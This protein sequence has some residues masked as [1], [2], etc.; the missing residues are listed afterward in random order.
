[1]LILKQRRLHHFKLNA[2]TSLV[3][4]FF[5]QLKTDEIPLFPD[6]GDGGSAAAHAVIKNAP[7][8]IS[9]STY[10]ILDKSYW[11]LRRVEGIGRMFFVEAYNA[12]WE[13]FI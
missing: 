7:P 11:L 9:I 8:H 5:V 13:F 4:I 6:A 2:L 1:M 3:V 10:K 12:L